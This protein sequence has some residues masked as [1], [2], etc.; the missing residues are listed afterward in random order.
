M[1]IFNYLLI[2]SYNIF[3]K[4]YIQNKM[5]ENKVN[6]WNKIENNFQIKRT[7]KKFYRKRVK[8]KQV[9]KENNYLPKKPQKIE[10]IPISYSKKLFINK[11]R[12]RKLKKNNEEISEGT[13]SRFSDDN[14][15]RK[16]KTHFHNYIIALLN[17]K[18]NI[19]L[20][21]NK[22]LK[23]GKMSSLITQNITVEY[24]QNL[25]NKKIKDII[26]DVSNKYQDKE[27]NI[28]CLNYA[29]NNPESNRELIKYLNMT[30][31]EMY[32][33]YYLKSV[34]SDFKNAEIDESYEKHIEKLQ[35]FGEKYIKN[36]EKNAKSLID[37]Y[38]KCKKR[39]RP[40][41]KEKLNGNCG[42][43]TLN[44][45]KEEIYL[46]DKE[47]NFQLSNKDEKNTPNSKISLGTQT[48]MKLT[49]DESEEE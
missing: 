37:F 19:D 45:S 16:I 14:L 13:H 36:Y 46:D 7:T 9:G 3:F 29:M 42:V 17:S 6:I 26:R 35:N 41:K 30:Y 11:K 22:N 38:N 34:K 44:N 4:N 12:G 27:I 2:Y 43:N 48:D 24:N 10:P 39:S 20:P 25:F 1:Q 49:D 40:N 32:L 28:K 18:L 15:K 5:T 31:K 23:F 47:N 33:N 8:I 21:N